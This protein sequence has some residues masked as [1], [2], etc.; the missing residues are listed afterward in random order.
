ML[1][2]NKLHNIEDYSLRYV[3]NVVVETLFLQIGAENATVQK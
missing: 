2:K 1:L 3:L